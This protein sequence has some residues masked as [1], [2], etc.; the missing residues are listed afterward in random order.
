ME[1]LI[2][3][4]WDA[5]S[6]QIFRF[7]VKNGSISGKNQK[8]SAKI[9]FLTE[10]SVKIGKFSGKINR[11]GEFCS[12]N[13]NSSKKS[14]AKLQM[15]GSTH[16]TVR[17]SF[18]A[19]LEQIFG[20]SRRNRRKLENFELKFTKINHKIKLRPQNRARTVQV[21][22]CTKNS[23]FPGIFRRKT[24]KKWERTE[25]LRRKMD[26]GTYHKHMIND[27]K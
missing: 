26:G 13:C 21:K 9:G 7:L 1:K 17:H 27:K 6:G 2:F 4:V 18:F 16:K 15:L 8:K 11:K 22:N 24:E 10:I 25:N 5:V 12:K 19:I 23:N 20:F 14:A 3:G